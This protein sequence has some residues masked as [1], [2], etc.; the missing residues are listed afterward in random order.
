MKLGLALCGGGIRGIAHAGILKCFEE[1]NIDIY[2]IAGTSAGSYIAIL[3][4]IGF[5]A[6]EIL[7]LFKTYADDLV[8]NDVKDVIFDQITFNKKIKFD[9]FRSGGPIEKLFNEVASQ[10]GYKN[11]NEIKMP[12][13]VIATNIK[14]EKECV[15]VSNTEKRSRAKEYVDNAEIGIAARASS[16]FSIVFDPCVYKDKILMDGGILNNIPVDEARFLGADF[17]IGINFRTTPI[18]KFSNVVDIG[19]KTLDMMGN[20]ISEYNWKDADMQITVD[21]DSAGFLDI[22]KIDYCYE[23]GYKTGKEIVALLKNNNFLAE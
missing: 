2:A 8:G 21:T 19:M 3:H 17:V 12:L 7:N 11:I 5:S 9:G 16:S 23:S 18:N 22:D 4:A 6:K 10:K 13:A 1:N 14:S 20:K 15:F